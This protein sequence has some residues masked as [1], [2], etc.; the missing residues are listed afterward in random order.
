MH[1]VPL[2]LPSPVKPDGHVQVKLPSLFTQ[3]APLTQSSVPSAHSSTSTCYKNELTSYSVLNNYSGK[4]T[5]MTVTSVSVAYYNYM[6]ARD[7]CIVYL[8]LRRMLDLGSEKCKQSI[9]IVH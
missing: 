8:E 1:P 7:I 9:I 4:Y 6:S 2:P 5:N 3:V